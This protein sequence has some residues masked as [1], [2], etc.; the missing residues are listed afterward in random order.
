MAGLL[1]AALAAL[2]QLLGWEGVD[3]AA[4]VYRVDAF[5]RWGF[6]LWDFRWYGG[7]WTLGYS[8][9]YPPLAATLGVA[10]L[11][12]VSAAA[13]AVA[14]DRLVVG[15]RGDR[16][17]LLGPGSRAASYVF[18]LGTVVPAA[19]GQLPFLTGAAFGLSS[20]WAAK[21]GRNVL[22]VF[23]A[24]ASTAS[25]PL[26]GAFVGLAF[27]AWTVPHLRSLRP[28]GGLVARNAL[29]VTAALVPVV[30]GVVLFP[31][32]GPMP[33]PFVD[34]AWE[35]A[36]AAGIALLAWR[37]WPEITSG[38][39]MFVVVASVSE[40]VPSALGGNVGRIEDLTALPLAVALAWARMRVLLPVVA[41]PLAMSQWVPAW[42][43][44][45]SIPTQPSTRASFFAPLDAELSRL[46]AS[47]PAGRVE[48]VP[49]AYHWEA[50]YVAPVMPLARGWER[51]LDEADNPIFYRSGD[52]TPERYRAWLESNGVTF[53]ALPRAPLD[54]AGKAE[55]RLVASGEVPGLRLAWHDEDWRLFTVT[56]ATGIVAGPA[57]LVR[58]DHGEVVVRA[59]EP[60]TVVVR[61]RYSPDWVMSSGIGCVSRASRSWIEVHVPRSEVFS[62]SL[63]LTGG[64][65][66]RLASPAAS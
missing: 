40:A 10:T 8:V 58:A 37:A 64:P 6:D 42:G 62:L 39:L 7:H 21:R 14:F 38:A 63:S 11:T 16:Q 27:A 31:G 59:P 36:V 48:V 22:A 34:Y 9:L 35:V 18:A 51:Q 66:C 13:A 45:T 5:R 28:H 56:G 65:A 47:E 50:A 3:M 60:G 29:M 2:A 57:R 44:M 54:M 52:L 26:A 19:I 4:Q 15:G 25:S 43:A 33:Y 30:A 23:L 55:G 49:T 17:G 12:V 46:A 53:V 41:V 20:L 61:V 1:A 24:L 32:D